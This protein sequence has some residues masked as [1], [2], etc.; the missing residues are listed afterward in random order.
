MK[1]SLVLALALVLGVASASMAATPSFSGNVTVK[2]T[3]SP[4][5]FGPF[6]LDPSARVDVDFAES[7]DSWSLDARLRASWDPKAG[8]PSHAVN[9]SLNRYKGVLTAGPVTATLAKNFGLGNIDTPFTWI[10]L[11]SNPND[12]GSPANYYDQL[13]LSA[14]LSGVQIDTQMVNNTDKIDVLK[15]RAQTQVDTLTLGAA[16]ELGLAG[17][18]SNYAVYGTT[19]LGIA[20]VKAIFGSFA[21]KSEYAVDLGAQVTEQLNIGA[22]YSSVDKADT[23]KGYAVRAKFT[24]GLLFA[25]ATYAE[26]DKETELWLKYRGSEN[27]QAFDDL[28]E[29]DPWEDDDTWAQTW[30][31]NVAPAFGVRY[32]DTETDDSQISLF[33]VAPLT[34]TAVGRAQFDTQ[35]GKTGFLVEARFK[36]NEKT[37]LNPYVDRDLDASDTEFGARLQYKVSDNAKVTAAASQEGSVQTLTAAYSIDF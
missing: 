31:Q 19:K 35:G 23:S 11:A 8:D 24:E 21:N 22:T 28:F 36:L 17:K 15:L 13:R 34:S 29:G 16:A 30:D 1:K 6:S 25:N 37:T 12:G 3:S 2:V 26:Q 18:D 33:A 14:N 32:S 10:R 4:E 27:N 7:G 20:E 5:F 9:V